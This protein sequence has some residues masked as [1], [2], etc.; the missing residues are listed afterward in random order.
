MNE[1]KTGEY[2]GDIIAAGFSN[3]CSARV[4][5]FGDA[6]L[7]TDCQEWCEIIREAE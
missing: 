3:C 4:Y 7:C 1:D 2:L 6:V 5:E